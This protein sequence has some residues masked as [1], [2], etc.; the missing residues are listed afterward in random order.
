LFLV[1]ASQTPGTA[2][3]VDGARPLEVF[4][5][6][7][8]LGAGTFSAS[9][10]EEI[11]FQDLPVPLR[12]LTDKRLPAKHYRLRGGEQPAFLSVASVGAPGTPSHHGICRVA[13]KGIDRDQAIDIATAGKNHPFRSRTIGINQTSSAGHALRV[14]QREGYTLLQTRTFTEAEKAAYSLYLERSAKCSRLTSPRAHR[15][16]AKPIKQGR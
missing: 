8:T 9:A 3:P 13:G 16:C 1:L 5:Q 15:I 12:R 11:A 10:L 4:R 2:P 7:C 14:W 6:V